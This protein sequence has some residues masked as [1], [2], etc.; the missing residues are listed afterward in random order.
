MTRTVE[1]RY[2]EKLRHDTTLL[3]NLNIYLLSLPS[4]DRKILIDNDMIILDF[5]SFP[6]LFTIRYHSTSEIIVC[7]TFN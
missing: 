3:N 1:K 4:T 5:F 7:S 2:A 6:L